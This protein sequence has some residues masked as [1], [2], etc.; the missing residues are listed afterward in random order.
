MHAFK[1]RCTAAAST[2]CCAP[3]PN[4]G[5]PRAR[6]R[7][8]HQDARALRQPLD[9]P[10]RGPQAQ[11]RTLRCTAPL[12]ARAPEQPALPTQ[13]QALVAAF[14]TSRLPSLG[15]VVVARRR[16]HQNAAGRARAARLQRQHPRGG[17]ASSRA[18]L[19]SSLQREH[20]DRDA[21]RRWVWRDLGRSRPRPRE[22]HQEGCMLAAAV[23]S[24]VRRS[25]RP[26]ALLAR[27]VLRSG[28]R[29][30]QTTHPTAPAPSP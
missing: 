17:H 2:Q 15:P 6:R 7:S 20:A 24:A 29:A 26:Y 25:Q 18:E 5:P 4:R 8:H 9:T 16:R 14:D 19:P 12:P 21:R 1:L 30:R 11:R 3:Q 23:L 10:A 13:P 27:A 28:R 22:C